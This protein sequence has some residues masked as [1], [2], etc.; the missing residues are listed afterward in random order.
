MQISGRHAC[1]RKK[2]RENKL[3]M[4][5]TQWSRAMPVTQYP[6]S[7]E[8]VT[9]HCSHEGNCTPART[10]S[11][12]TSEEVSSW[13]AS[14]VCAQNKGV[15]EMDGDLPFGFSKQDDERRL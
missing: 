12:E 2:N 11:L 5:T 9:V 13:I 10:A 6:R 8:T 1:K 4:G 3:V 7:S 14:L 15:K